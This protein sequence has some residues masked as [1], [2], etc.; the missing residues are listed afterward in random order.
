MRLNAESVNI[1]K[2]DLIE[3]AV[4]VLE[5]AEHSSTASQLGKA[6]IAKGYLKAAE[7]MASD[8]IM[9]IDLIAR[10]RYS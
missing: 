5:D 10:P 1:T 2:K 3:N 7:L 9:H 4:R 8:S 6:E